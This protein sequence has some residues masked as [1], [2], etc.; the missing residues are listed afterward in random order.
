[1][2]VEGAVLAAANLP[3]YGHSAAALER[4][5]VDHTAQR[6]AAV[7]GRGWPPGYRDPRHVAEW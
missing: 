2:G 3:A 7:Q 4:D 1:M 5:D 6:V